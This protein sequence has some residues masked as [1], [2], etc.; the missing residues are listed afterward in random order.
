MYR[1]LTLGTRILLAVGLVPTGMIKLPGW[2]FTRISTDEPIGAFFEVM[3][4]SGEYRRFLG[5]TQVPAG[6]LVLLPATATVGAML[7]FGI[8]LNIFVIATAYGFGNTQLLTGAM[9]GATLYL[10]MWDYH[11][12]RSG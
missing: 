7:F 2:R 6:A 12:R 9:L 1:R 11:R 5:L 3:Y 8:I 4:Q 10:M